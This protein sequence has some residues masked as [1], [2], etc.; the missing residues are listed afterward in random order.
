MVGFIYNLLKSLLSTSS[1]HESL[2]VSCPHF[3]GCFLKPYN[4]LKVLKVE[5]MLGLWCLLPWLNFKMIHAFFSLLKKASLG[6]VSLQ[7]FSSLM[8]CPFTFWYRCEIFVVVFSS[9]SLKTREKYVSFS[10]VLREWEGKKCAIT[11]N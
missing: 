8:H 6:K 10:L 1:I 2:C 11:L 3:P 9:R 7:L 4:C 5:G